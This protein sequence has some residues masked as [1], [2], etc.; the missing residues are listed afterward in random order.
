MPNNLSELKEKHVLVTG[1]CG[2]IGSEVT[3]QLSDVGAKI[4]VLDNLSSGKNEYV[5]GIPNVTIQNGELGDSSLIH[6]LI[7][8]ID[9]VINLAALPFIPDSF[10]YPKEFFE[11]NVDS[12]INLALEVSKQKISND[13]FIYHLARYMEV[14]D[15]H[16]WM[17]IILQSLNQPMQ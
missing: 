9:Y 16:L 4:I 11:V 3:K 10:Y 8:D 17:K 14:Q 7:T 13:L 15:M 2:F 6:S 12:T 5:K 1:G